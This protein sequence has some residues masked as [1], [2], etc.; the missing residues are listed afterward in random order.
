[1]KHSVLYADSQ[2]DFAVETVTFILRGCSLSAAIAVSCDGLPF[3]LFLFKIAIG[4]VL[5][6]SHVFPP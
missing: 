5:Q 3:D 2:V 6:F 1:M 4:T